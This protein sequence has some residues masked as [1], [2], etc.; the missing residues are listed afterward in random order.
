MKK[1]RRL[2]RAEHVAAGVQGVSQLQHVL[3]ENHP[4]AAGPMAA[5]P[6]DSGPTP[7]LLEGH[8]L[9]CQTKRQFTVDGEETMKNGAVRKYGKCTG[10]GCSRTISMFVKGA[11]D[12]A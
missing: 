6:L 1:P 11:T 2:Y 8:C 7:E 3:L 4:T 10:S 9:G 12:A 5:A